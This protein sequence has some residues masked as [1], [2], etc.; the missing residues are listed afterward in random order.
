[1]VLPETNAPR[2]EGVG[3]SRPPASSLSEPRAAMTHLHIRLLGTRHIDFGGQDLGLPQRSDTL[4]LLAC[5]LLTSEEPW[6]R[7]ELSQRL[8]PQAEPARARANLRH[9]LHQLKRWLPPRSP[10]NAWLVLD[11]KQVGWNPEAHSWSDVQ[12][13]QAAARPSNRPRQSRLAELRDALALCNGPLLPGLED[14]WTLASRADLARCQRRA[15]E[16]LGAGLEQIGD[17]LAATEQGRALLTLDPSHEPSHRRLMRLHAARGD[18][19]AVLS[20]SQDCR[21]ALRRHLGTV[22]DSETEA[23]LAQLL[24]EA[25]LGAEKKAPPKR[26]TGGRSRLQEPGRRYASRIDDLDRAAALD[27]AMGETR[28]LTVWGP[29][30]VGKS[31]LAGHLMRNAGASRPVIHIALDGASDATALLERIAAAVDAR[32]GARTHAAIAAALGRT[33]QTLLLDDCEQVIDPLAELSE[34]LLGRCSGLRLVITSRERLRIRGELALSVPR[35]TLEGEARAP[36][37]EAGVLL[38]R[39]LDLDMPWQAGMSD[40]LLAIGQALD[41][42]P[43]AI[44]QAALALQGRAPALLARELLAD[45]CRIDTLALLEGERFTGLATS[46]EHDLRRLATGPRRVLAR[47]A[48]A[49]AALSL[50]ALMQPEPSADPSIPIPSPAALIEDLAELRARALVEID[51]GDDGTTRY[52]L[53]NSTRHLARQRFQPKGSE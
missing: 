5:L 46:F 2:S 15:M 44:L 47:L 29:G 36:A 4:R 39:C 22:P 50:P 19:A 8:W 51:T 38:A 42:L 35:L 20:Q 26:Q 25:G 43:R 34:S 14:A 7:A 23:L 53:L 41:G 16:Q 30:G 52:R 6:S 17:I 40:T 33:D 28:L 31:C 1:M 37:G 32:P 10:E 21:D 9:G 11:R 27:E 12:A 45:P 18:R 49:D 24:G 48:S 3:S 13:L